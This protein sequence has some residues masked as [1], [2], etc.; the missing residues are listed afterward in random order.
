MRL[1]YI[2]IRI[3]LYPILQYIGTLKKKKNGN[4]IWGL[5]QEGINIM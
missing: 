3:L 1:Q 2:K 5:F 4:R